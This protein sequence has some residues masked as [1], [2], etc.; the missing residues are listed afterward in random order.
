MEIIRTKEVPM[1]TAVKINEVVEYLK[2]CEYEGGF[3]PVIHEEVNYQDPT[4]ER[5]CSKVMCQIDLKQDYY[6]ID[7]VELVSTDDDVHILYVHYIWQ[8]TFRIIVK[9]ID[10]VIPCLKKHLEG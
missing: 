2:S 9:G 1:E 5:H 8:K 3:V 10:N 6:R 7:R 4:G